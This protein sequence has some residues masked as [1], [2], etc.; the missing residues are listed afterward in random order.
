MALE[1]EVEPIAADKCPAC[2]GRNLTTTS[3]TVD[4]STYWRCLTCGEVWN[5]KRHAVPSR[6][7]YRR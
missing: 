1:R 4:A 7:S 5:L 3:K 6:F 2:G